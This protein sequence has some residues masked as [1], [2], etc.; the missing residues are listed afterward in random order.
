M[1]SQRLVLPP[2]RDGDDRGALR[3]EPLRRGE[4]HRGDAEE[5]DTAASDARAGGSEAHRVIE[6]RRRGTGEGDGRQKNEKNN[7]QAH[8]PTT[9][10][11]KLST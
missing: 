7:H 9:V 5:A 1:G 6:G 4:R 10:E 8:F 11:K 3:R 2:R